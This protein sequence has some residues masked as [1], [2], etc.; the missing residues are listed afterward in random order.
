MDKWLKKIDQWH[1]SDIFWSV[2]TASVL[3]AAW[4]Q[5]IQHGWINPDTVLYFEHAR[6]ISLGD[7][8]G[9]MA[10]YPWP[11]YGAAIAAVH[12]LGF[13]IHFAAQLLNMLFFG[14]AMAGFLKIIQL[15]GGTNRAMLAGTLLVFGSQYIVG[16][17]LEMLMRDEGFWAFYLFA[18]FFFMRFYARQ[19]TQDAISWQLCIGIA[20][21]FRIEGLMY[22]AFL[23]LAWLLRQDMPIA[24][25]T[26][27]MLASYSLSLIALMLLIIVIAISPQLNVQ[28]FGRLNEIFTFSL[29]QE[30]INKL[31]MQADIMSEQV[32]GKYLEE[33]AVQGLLLTFL[34]IIAAKIVTATGFIGLGL[35]WFGVKSRQSLFT[36]QIYTVMLTILAI[37]LMSML[38]TI[39]KV[40]VLSGRY[41]VPFAWILLIFSAFFWT[42]LSKQK[43]NHWIHVLICIVLL[44]GFIKNI[45]PKQ[46]GYNYQQQAV[47]WIHTNKTHNLSIF[48][49]DERVRFYAGA[50]FIGKDLDSLALIKAA[51]KDGSLNHYQI[52]M[53]SSSKKHAE[54]EQFVQQNLPEFKEIKRFSSNKKDKHLIVYKKTQP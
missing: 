19:A 23:P 24:T 18:I 8:H 10:V 17:V 40:F 9:A 54:G 16:D 41:V 46:D 36:K 42:A 52:L 32:L 7:W 43:P 47:E 30:L 25:R 50:P 22:A 49:D 6:L 31:L 27:K 44:F 29:H 45:L 26:T 12:K 1:T 34:Y 51:E 48:Y 2:V 13:S 37:S 33:F 11:F 38:F 53:V 3:L 5:Y 20:T 4:M 35:A 21:L 14:I 15:A 39:T 28:D